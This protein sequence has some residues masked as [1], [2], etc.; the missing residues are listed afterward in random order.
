M[1]NP[2]FKW[3]ATVLD[4]VNQSVLAM[5]NTNNKIRPDI[6]VLVQKIHCWVKKYNTGLLFFTGFHL[7]VAL[8]KALTLMNRFARIF[9]FKLLSNLIMRLFNITNL[10]RWRWC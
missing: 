8:I 5:H 4:Q 3:D 9:L 1:L 6:K 7:F 2:G 10:N